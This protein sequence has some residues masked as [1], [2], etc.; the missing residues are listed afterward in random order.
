MCRY[1][2]KLA[3]RG[4][5]GPRALCVTIAAQLPESDAVECSRVHPSRSLSFAIS[6]SRVPKMRRVRDSAGLLIVRYDD[7]LSAN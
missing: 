4:R 1:S 7:W 3:T 5:N 2:M 6:T